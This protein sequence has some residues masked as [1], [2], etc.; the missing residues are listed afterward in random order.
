MADGEKKKRLVGASR[1]P[2]SP[3]RVKSLAEMIGDD[4]KTADGLGISYTFLRSI[5]NGG[6][7]KVSRTLDMAA[8]A[9][10][11]RFGRASGSGKAIATIKVASPDWK[12]VNTMISACGGEVVAFASCEDNFPH[13]NETS[14]VLAVATIPQSGVET[15]ERFIS[16]LHGAFSLIEGV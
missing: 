13:T 5:I 1:F 15:A 8:E 14:A 7:T 2:T 4:H 11:K 12:A 16:A 3:A 6:T 10:L 9:G